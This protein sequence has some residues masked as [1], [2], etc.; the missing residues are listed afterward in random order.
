QL[1]AVRDGRVRPVPLAAV[2]E[3]VRRD[4]HH[5][6]DQAAVDTGEAGE[7]GGRHWGGTGSRPG[8]RP[9]CRR[10]PASPV[11]RTTRRSP[12]LGQTRNASASRAASAILGVCLVLGKTKKRGCQTGQ[13][14]ALNL[15][16]DSIWNHLDRK[17]STER[18]ARSTGP[19]PI[20]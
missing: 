20:F 6:H 14:L 8:V 15:Y 5:A 10:S 17:M 7:P 11:L 12:K 4:V 1:Q 2:G 13:N 3:R 16:S 18:Q 19:A 9:S